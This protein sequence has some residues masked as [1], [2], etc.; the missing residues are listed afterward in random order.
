MTHHFGLT[1]TLD[2]NT[3]TRG[4]DYTPVK[5]L[6]SH[7]RHRPPIKGF[8]LTE[9][10]VA[11]AII[12]A[13]LG[14]VAWFAKFVNLHRV[15]S[16]RKLKLTE[17]LQRVM[18][19]IENDF[20]SARRHTLCNALC[21]NIV[22]S[23]WG[24][25]YRTTSDPGFD[26]D[27]FRLTEDQ[28]ITSQWWAPR[29]SLFPGLNTDFAGAMIDRNPTNRL[30]GMG[31]MAIWSSY[32]QTALVYSVRS[33]LIDGLRNGTDY[34]LAGWVRSDNDGTGITMTANLILMNSAG[35]VL[36]STGTQSSNWGYV[37][38][39]LDGF[40]ASTLT[41]YY[42]I[43]ETRNVGKPSR[44]LTAHF[45]NI[46]LTPTDIIADIDFTSVAGQTPSNIN[47]NLNI[48]SNFGTVFYQ[49]D[50]NTGNS[51]T[52][53]PGDMLEIN[54]LFSRGGMQKFPVPPRDIDL[55]RFTAQ[56][57]YF[58]PTGGNPTWNLFSAQRPLRDISRLRVSWVGG[59]AAWTRGANRPIQIDVTV[60]D[61]EDASKTLSYSR[62]LFPPTD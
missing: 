56:P 55:F 32:N 8:T 2:A 22:F 15:N 53:T 30:F 33:P 7:E 54:Y 47:T 44:V 3:E 52:V 48:E 46:T 29:L 28:A 42:V 1:L 34:V 40:N 4:T 37:A 62:T 58:P 6:R 21:S 25:G 59:D 9:L 45:D 35:T 31:S 11:V 18:F 60:R 36:A 24:K 57:P 5:D 20:L 23:F 50:L 49:T 26:L 61:H 27:Y 38:T 43:L 39:R 19:T 13:L 14:M 17:K 51:A 41:D 16:E 12:G 10:I